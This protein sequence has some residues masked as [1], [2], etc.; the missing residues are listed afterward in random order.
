MPGAQSDVPVPGAAQNALEDLD[1]LWSANTAVVEVRTGSD[2]A[3][4]LGKRDAAETPTGEN[5]LTLHFTDLNI[6][7]DELAGYGPEVLVL[8]P[9]TAAPGRAHPP[10]RGARRPLRTGIRTRRNSGSVTS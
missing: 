1:R 10:D 2:A 7:A 6:L 8:S 3:L 5:L 9:G 4:R